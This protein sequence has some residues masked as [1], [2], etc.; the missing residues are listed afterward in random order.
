MFSGRQGAETKKI[1]SVFRRDSM[2]P[3]YKKLVEPLVFAP[4]FEE[5]CKDVL[6]VL[7]TVKWTGPACATKIMRSGWHFCQPDRGRMA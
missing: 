7:V 4:G 2:D 1:P 3:R 6:S 5:A